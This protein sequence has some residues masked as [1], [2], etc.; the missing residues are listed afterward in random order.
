MDE[1][2]ESEKKVPAAKSGRQYQT[3]LDQ[4]EDIA[5]Q[6][7]ALKLVSQNRLHDKFGRPIKAVRGRVPSFTLTRFALLALANNGATTETPE[8]ASDQSTQNGE[9]TVKIE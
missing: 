2:G 4:A 7:I 6:S 5:V 9:E 3:I 8:N 1:T